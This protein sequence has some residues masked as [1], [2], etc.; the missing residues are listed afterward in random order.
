MKNVRRRLKSVAHE[1]KRKSL[2]VYYVAR[3]PRTPW[4][5]RGMAMVVAA[6][7]F[8]P[9]DLI[10]DFI[11]ILG[12]LDDLILIPLGVYLV[13]RVLPEPI[14]TDAARLAETASERPVSRVALVVIALIWLLVAHFAYRL[15]V[16][17]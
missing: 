5:L 12:V 4:W 8:S 9:I 15:V 16:K 7:A 10:P 17:Q 11:P 13:L 1:L 6:Y 3:D 14:R 2:W